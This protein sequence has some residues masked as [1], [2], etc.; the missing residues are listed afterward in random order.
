MA[1]L[2]RPHGFAFEYLL[3][4]SGAAPLVDGTLDTNVSIVPGDA[5]AESTT[6]YLTI[7]TATSAAIKGVS[8]STVAGAAGVRPKILLIAAL[9]NA[10]FSG[11]CS[12]TG[13]QT[14]VGEDVD[15]EGTTGI[16]QLDENA[17]SL[18]VVHIIGLKPDSAL[19]A[20]AEFLFV[21]KASQFTGQA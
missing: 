13:A 3:G 20:N 8:A 10:V 6:G 1:N 14:N 17:S 12:G 11:Q 18:K 2:N 9:P 15:I 5:L 19:G 21:W 4:S 7:A 16:M